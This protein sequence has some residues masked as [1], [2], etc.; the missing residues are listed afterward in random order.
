VN[1]VKIIPT[2]AACLIMWCTRLQRHVGGRD[3]IFKLLWRIDVDMSNI[4][5]S[6][7]TIRFISIIWGV[8]GYGLHRFE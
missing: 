5:S 7:D 1:F 4:D 3:R 2:V 6:L 8:T